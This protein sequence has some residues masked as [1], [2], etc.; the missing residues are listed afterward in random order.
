MFARS[1]QI[2]ETLLANIIGPNRGALCGGPNC[3]TRYA[4][5]NYERFSR[6]TRPDGKRLDTALWPRRQAL[7]PAG[8][9]P[10]GMSS[11]ITGR[12]RPKGR[13]WA[14]DGS[15]LLVTVKVYQSNDGR[16]FFHRKSGG[17]DGAD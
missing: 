13:R 11:G 2:A 12:L 3:K 1:D 9:R 14:V 7:I 15:L 5:E 6:L 8:L 4:P 17:A 16:R 10:C